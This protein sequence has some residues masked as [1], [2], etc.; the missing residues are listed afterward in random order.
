MEEVK[1]MK[2]VEKV[3]QNRRVH[4]VGWFPEGL[5]IACI[6]LEFSKNAEKLYSHFPLTYFLEGD[7][8][9]A[10]VVLVATR[11]CLGIPFYKSYACKAYEHH[12][13]LD[14]TYVP[15]LKG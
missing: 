8:V 14:K 15:I 3:E 7:N 9:S 2:E 6:A 4:I 10:G 1:E 13:A 11:S 12:L 5:G